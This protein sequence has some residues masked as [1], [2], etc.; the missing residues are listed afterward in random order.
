[1]IPS[2]RMTAPSAGR[3]SFISG[4]QR[5]QA[6]QTG[7]LAFLRQWGK[8]VNTKQEHGANGNSLPVKLVNGGNTISTSAAA[9]SDHNRKKLF[10]M[11]LTN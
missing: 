3:S 9:F 6:R 7:L 10:L 11:A 5:E 2:I 8:V 1:M 4:A